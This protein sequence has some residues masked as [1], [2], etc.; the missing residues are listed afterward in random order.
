MNEMMKDVNAALSDEMADGTGNSPLG[1]EAVADSAGNTTLYGYTR[2]TANRLSPDAA[3]DTY[4]E[5][6]G[7]VTDALMR[8]KLSNMESEGS[9]KQDIAIVTDPTGR[10]YLF[11]LMDELKRHL[12]SA[13]VDFGFN[14][15]KV[16]SY[17][18]VPIIVDA[19]CTS[20]AAT[21]SQIYFIDTSVDVIAVG[22]EPK[23]VSLAKVGAA[24]EGYLEFHFAHVYKQPRRIGM[25]N[26]LT[27]P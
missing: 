22:M 4:S 8:A 27:G 11:N 16:P 19:D 10:D 13:D 1:L 5:V 26:T 6:G 18:G 14:R 15:M 24:T 21:N 2:S 12:G 9:R 17:D 23:L 20:T 7:S 3:G 25:L